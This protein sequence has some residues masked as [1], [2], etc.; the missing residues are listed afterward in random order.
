MV[1]CRSAWAR[2]FPYVAVWSETTVKWAWR[3]QASAERCSVLSP[4]VRISSLS[5]WQSG[6][7]P[8]SRA[9]SEEAERCGMTSAIASNKHLLAGIGR[10]EAGSTLLLE[11]HMMSELGG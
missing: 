6:S 8:Q 9:Q 2:G 5:S 3:R 4:M 1:K 10:V 11:G 7:I